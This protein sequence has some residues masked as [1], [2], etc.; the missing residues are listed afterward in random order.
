MDRHLSSQLIEMERMIEKV[1]EAE[2]IQSATAGLDR[3]HPKE[4]EFESDEEV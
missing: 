3:I 4:I 1:M 2:F